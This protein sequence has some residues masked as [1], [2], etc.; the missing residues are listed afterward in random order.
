MLLELS[1][2]GCR[3]L[4]AVMRKRGGLWRINERVA[5]ETWDAVSAPEMA[6]SS[7]GGPKGRGRFIYDVHKTLEFL[8]PLVRIRSH[9]QQRIHATFLSHIE[10]W[11]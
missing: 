9:I 1:S 11:T 2:I 5:W 10:G 6:P 7:T 4:F 8:D 3:L